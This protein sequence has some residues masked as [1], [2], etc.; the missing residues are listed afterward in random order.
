MEHAELLREL[1]LTDAEAAV[2]LALLETGRSKAGSII[3]KAGLHRATT[4]QIIQRLT[5]KGLAS[6]IVEG[7]KRYFTA[8]SPRRL[9]DALRGREERL[10]QALP[11]LEA[12]SVAGKEKQE[13]TVYSGVRG[14]RSALDRMLEE[15]GKGG[16]YSDFGVS[17]LFREVMGSYFQ[18]WQ[19][20]KAEKRI[21]SHVIFNE[22]LKKNKEFFEEYYGEARFHPKE[23]SSLTDTMI[24]N[25]TVILLIWT[26]KPPVAVVIRNK[27]NAESYRNQFRLMWKN[28]KK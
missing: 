12:M 1:G 11:G 18:S 23:Y 19:R 21:I 9:L 13:I 15:I 26:A 25:D 27:D 4:Y 5:E 3:R 20:K 24:Y 8:A 16:E 17:G 22:G 6:A 10:K 28:A 14:I 7:K 2:Y